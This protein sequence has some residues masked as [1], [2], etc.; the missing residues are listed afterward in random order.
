MK[1]PYASSDPDARPPAGPPSRP[2]E[3]AVDSLLMLLPSLI[4]ALREAEP[5]SQA[6]QR[7]GGAGLTSRQ[8]TA[9][10]QLELAGEQ[11]MSDFAAG[12]GVSRAT[13]TDVAERLEERGLVT[14]RHSPTDRRVIL[15][16]LSAAAQAEARA[17]LDRRRRDI[18]QALDR[19]PDVPA[20]AI[21]DF[22]GTLIDELGRE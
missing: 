3:A 14:R 22:I 12:M 9:L 1:G 21:A 10:I 4:A 5:H 16:K 20:Q 13:A 17:V 19:R 7:L 2:D 6:R 15:L 8:M 18:R 11:T